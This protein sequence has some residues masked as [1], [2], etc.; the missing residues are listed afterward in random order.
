MKGAGETHCGESLKGQ[1]KHRKQEQKE[2]RKDW[3]EV[4]V[5]SPADALSICG[6]TAEGESG[7]RAL[8]RVAPWKIKN[9]ARRT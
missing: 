5:A 3:W 9:T 7:R 8:R 4:W 1:V 2:E 6:D